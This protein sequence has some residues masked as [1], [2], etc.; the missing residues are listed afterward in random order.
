MAGTLS[1][2]GGLNGS[3]AQRGKLTGTLAPVGQLTGSISRPE[4]FYDY[5]EGG[6]EVTPTRETQMLMTN[7]KYLMGNV[8]V[9]PI[10]SNYGLITWN[11]QCLTVS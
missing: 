8:I 5:Y 2:V 9:N 1:L 4:S 6:Y 10:P 3:L 11:G 7:R